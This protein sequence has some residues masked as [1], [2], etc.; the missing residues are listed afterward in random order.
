MCGLICDA[1]SCSVWRRDMG[2][3]GVYDQIITENEKKRK[4]GNKS[5]FT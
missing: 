4:Y 2:K 1:I 5:D 3:I